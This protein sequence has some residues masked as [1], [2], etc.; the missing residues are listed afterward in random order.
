MAGASGTAELGGK[1][2]GATVLGDK[3]DKKSLSEFHGRGGDV[4]PISPA[5]GEKP[6]LP[7]KVAEMAAPLSAE[8]KQ[9]LEGRRRAAEL[10]GGGRDIP[11]EVGDGEKRRVGS[12]AA[13]L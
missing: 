9:E 11:V 7:L 13:D 3:K 12:T 8:E 4:S 2:V 10:S 5:A 1:S 6:S